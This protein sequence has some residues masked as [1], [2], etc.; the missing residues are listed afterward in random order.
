MAD[1]AAPQLEF[2]IRVI[3]VTPLQQ[4]ASLI[5][6]TETMEGVFVDPGGE[7]DRLMETA[8]ELGV[9]IGAVWLTHGH[10]DHVGAAHA[11]KERTGCPIIGPHKDDQFLLDKIEASGAK[12]GIPEAKNFQ[13]DRYLDEGDTVELAGIVFGVLHC[14]GHSPGHVVLYQQEQA[15][16]FVGDVLFRGSIGRTDLAQGDHKQLINSVTQKL[17]PLGGEMRFVPGHGPASTFGQERLDNPF[18]ADHVLGTTD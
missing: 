13:P 1:S 15:F 5:W 11:V 12:Y 3:T 6:S 9:K 7:I 4:N 2:E 18:V 8:D 10:F 16:A 17:W 14:P